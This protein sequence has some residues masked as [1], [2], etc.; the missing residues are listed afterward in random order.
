[1]INSC[2]W[3]KC[4]LFIKIINKLIGPSFLIGIVGLAY[5]ELF[6]GLL[7][8]A[9]FMIYLTSRFEEIKKQKDNLN[10]KIKSK[11]FLK[12]INN[13]QSQE[14][15]NTDGEKEHSLALSGQSLFNIA[16]IFFKRNHYFKALYLYERA[17]EK[18]PMEY[19]KKDL[20]SAIIDS[21]HKNV[22]LINTKIKAT[23]N[24]N[25]AERRLEESKEDNFSAE[26][27]Y[28][29]AKEYEF[30]WHT[31]KANFLF[32][33]AGR[34]GLDIAVETLFDRYKRGTLTSKEVVS[35]ISEVEL[36]YTKVMNDYGYHLEHYAPSITQ[37]ADEDKLPYPKNLIK[38]SIL[39]AIILSKDEEFKSALKVSYSSLSNYQPSIGLDNL[40]LSYETISNLNNLIDK[41][42]DNQRNDEEA[43]KI[44]SDLDDGMKEF[45]KHNKNIQTE[46]I[47]LEK[48]ISNPF[49]TISKNYLD[50]SVE[51]YFKNLLLHKEF[52]MAKGR[53]LYT[54]RF[55]DNL[56]SDSLLSLDTENA[57]IEES[58]KN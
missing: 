46:A 12:F 53:S 29:I 10:E 23:D 17:L 21:I 38:R 22:S 30:W 15:T 11:E 36:F 55:E 20:P 39:L 54:K 51:K 14:V 28:T 57:E 32:I 43:E 34:M 2:P 26:D 45:E 4:E 50:F 37:V 42:I 7:I 56:K 49:K 18:I 27:I 9:L 13:L 6:W 33:K 44:I 41:N 3:G 1:L 40:G 5:S 24:S 31:N 58:L 8:S 48:E 47:T 25:L 35:T 19:R 16:E 52:Y